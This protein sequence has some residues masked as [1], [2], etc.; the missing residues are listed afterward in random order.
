MQT[1]AL[2]RITRQK[3][4]TQL[5]TPLPLWQTPGL[6]LARPALGHWGRDAPS[7][8]PVLPVL[9]ASSGQTG[10]VHL[11]GRAGSH[12]HSLAT[13]RLGRKYMVT[14]TSVFE[15]RFSSYQSSWG[16]KF[17]KHR[18]R[19]EIL[20]RLK[21]VNAYPSSY[22]CT[23]VFMPSYSQPPSQ[24]PVPNAGIS[25]SACFHLHTFSWDFICFI[26]LW[27]LNVPL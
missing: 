7:L 20:G 25:F 15:G 4:L 1:G 14:S 2:L 8:H 5:L 10:W 26:V 22:A 11:T 19:A 23:P 27:L 9:P 21:M 16:K 12:V 13:G 6:Q 18:K 24:A 3:H 17:L